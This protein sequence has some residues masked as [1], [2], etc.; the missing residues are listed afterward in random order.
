MKRFL[1]ILLVFLLVCAPMTQA[2]ALGV[3]SAGIVDGVIDDAYGLRGKQKKKDIPSRSLP[4]TVSD[5][6]EGTKA[7]AITMVDPDGGDWVHWLACNIPVREEIPANASISMSKK[8]TQGKNDFKF[9]G[10]GGPTPPSG[11]HRYVI[12]VYALSG[13]VKLKKGFKLGA[14]EKAIRGKVL[15]SAEILGDYSR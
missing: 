7:L 6:P 2:L 12:T 13:K 4:L 10:Y 9:V 1:G 8:M 3:Q 15:E 5:I 11:T 14:F